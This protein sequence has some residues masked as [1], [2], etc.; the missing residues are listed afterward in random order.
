MIG[1][2]ILD[3]INAFFHAALCRLFIQLFLPTWVFA[4]LANPSRHLLVQNQQQKHQK[5]V[6]NLFK[7][8][9]KV[10]DFVLFCL[11][12]ALKRFHIL[13]WCFWLAL[14]RFNILFWCFWCWLWTSNTF[15][16]QLQITKFRNTLTFVRV[17]ILKTNQRKFYELINVYCFLWLRFIQKTID[18]NKIMR[19]FYKDT[20]FIGKDFICKIDCYYYAFVTNH[21]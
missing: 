8:N 21:S 13:F 14:K 19:N 17:K 4:N 7:V 20:I 3:K 12:L 1:K 18:S 16:I 6:W 15:V 2:H 11:L 9:N 10:N 5:N